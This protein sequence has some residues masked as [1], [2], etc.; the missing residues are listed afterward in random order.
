MQINARTRI[1]DPSDLS[2]E[3]ALFDRYGETLQQYIQLARESVT[4]FMDKYVLL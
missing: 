3:Y 4:I 1:R 2:S